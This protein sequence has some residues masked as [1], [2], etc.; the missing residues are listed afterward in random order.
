MGYDFEIHYNP[1]MTNKV[2][3]A[4]SRRAHHEEELD[5]ICSTHVI[6][7]AHLEDSVNQDP[8]LNSVKQQLLL[9]RPTL[10]GLTLHNGRLYYKGRFVLPNNSAYIPTLLYLYHDSPTDGHFGEHKTYQRLAQDWFW[11][12]MKK[13]IAEYVKACETCQRHKH[14]TLSPAGLLQPLPIPNLVW[15]HVSMDFVEGLP[16][17]KGKNTVLVVFNRLTKYV[18]FI[19]PP[20][21]IYR[22]QCSKDLH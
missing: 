10:Q 9:Q 17:A 20:S 6:D 5:T 16:K 2:A 4:L 18:H 19:A 22:R 7:W 14:S 21:S 13:R 1:G 8:M 11:E 12:G 3:D 15:E